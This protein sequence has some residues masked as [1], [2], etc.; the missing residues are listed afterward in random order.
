MDSSAIDRGSIGT[1]KNPKKRVHFDEDSLIDKAESPH[2]L[3]PEQLKRARV[4]FPSK[5][6]IEI[7]RQA[8]E[9]DGGLA[10]QSL[11]VP[12]NHSSSQGIYGGNDL[13]ALN[14]SK[15]PLPPS[16]QRHFFIVPKLSKATRES[17]VRP[18]KRP[19]EAARSSSPPLPLSNDSSTKSC[20]KQFDEPSPSALRKNEDI[21][22]PAKKIPFAAP[23]VAPS[24]WGAAGGGRDQKVDIAPKGTDLAARL[25]KNQGEDIQKYIADFTRLMVLGKDDIS[26]VREYM[27]ESNTTLARTLTRSILYQSSINHMCYDKLFIC[28]CSVSA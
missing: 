22:V 8:A 7:C 4:N 17:S 21:I 3:S 24:S 5:Q 23:A 27:H 1:V 11:S 10:E 2:R 6:E 26:D 13:N 25:R 18:L 28:R 19:R 20:Q 9:G 14:S 16:Q 15:P 12:Q